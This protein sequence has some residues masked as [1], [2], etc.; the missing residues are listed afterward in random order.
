MS[1]TLIYWSPTPMAK[2]SRS[3]T[4]DIE[5]MVGALTVAEFC[6]SQKITIPHFYNLRK[7]GEATNS[8]MAGTKRLIAVEEVRAWQKRET[9]KET[10][11]TRKHFAKKKAASTVPTS[12]HTTTA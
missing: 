11:R 10:Q 9:K 8:F 4:D 5:S 12:D 3:E 1:S 2:K 7:R 6:K